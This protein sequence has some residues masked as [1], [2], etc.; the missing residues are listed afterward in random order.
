MDGKIFKDEWVAVAGSCEGSMAVD[1]KDVRE[2]L[3][4]K[5]LR[6]RKC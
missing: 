5:R 4:A 3:N 6:V 2:G 1:V